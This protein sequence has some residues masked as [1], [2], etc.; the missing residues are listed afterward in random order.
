[1][2]R[3]GIAAIALPAPPSIIKTVFIVFFFLLLSLQGH[4]SPGEFYSIYL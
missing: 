4:D 2:I 3:A 1:L